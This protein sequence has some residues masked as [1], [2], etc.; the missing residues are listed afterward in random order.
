MEFNEQFYNRLFKLVH[1]KKETRLIETRKIVQEVTAHYLA[2][3]ITEI[4]QNLPGDEPVPIKLDPTS[5][6]VVR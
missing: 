6:A 5:E 3:G 1:L 4:W 2:N